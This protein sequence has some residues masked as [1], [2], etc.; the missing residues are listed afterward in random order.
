MLLTHELTQPIVDKTMAIIKKNINIMDHRAVIIASG[1][2]DRL[3]S[4]HEGAARVIANGHS[5][6]ISTTDMNVLRGVRPGVNLPIV[7]GGKIAGV[8]GISG[9]PEE[10]RSSGELVRVA[11]EL[12]LEQL[13][14]KEQLNLE[15][16][17]RESFMQELLAGE[18]GPNEALFLARASI[19]SYDLQ[20]PRYAIVIDVDRFGRVVEEKLSSRDDMRTG[21]LALQQLKEGIFHTIERAFSISG[22]ELIAFA[23]GDKFVVLKDSKN[24]RINKQ[25]KQEVQMVIKK[26]MDDIYQDTGLTVTVGV[27]KLYGDYRQYAQSYKEALAAIDTGQ[28]LWGRGKAYWAED[29][30]VENL[31]A[32]LP[33]KVLRDYMQEVLG[34]LLKEGEARHLDETLNTL[35][36]LFEHGLNV[37]R[38]ARALFVHRNTVIFR[39]EKLE[40]LTGYRPSLSFQDA[41][42]LKL[43]IVA[44]RYLQ[45]E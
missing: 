4:F 21:E 20:I 13:V 44:W 18:S 31:L 27:G 32:I 38:A 28:R 23:G 24:W 6:E 1:D 42:K 39:L 40:E 11:V 30:P 43:A 3:G 9:D 25:Q 7:F 35:E 45:A 15:T 17:A 34:P 5:M 14:L 26:V 29:M 37:T 41:L 36:A 12:M 33:G 19:L 2:R 10:V 16:R 22:K 8:V